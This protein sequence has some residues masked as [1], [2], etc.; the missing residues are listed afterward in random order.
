M[1]AIPLL[2][3]SMPDPEHS[4]VQEKTMTR[5]GLFLGSVAAGEGLPESKKKHLVTNADIEACT[6]LDPL[7]MQRFNEA[8]IAGRKRAWSVL[9]FQE[10]FGRIAE[11]KTMKQAEME[12]RGTYNA[13]LSELINMDSDLHAQYL[14]ALESRSHVVLEPI[15]ETVE[16]RSRDTLEGFKGPIPNMAA[17]SRDKLIAESR[18]RVAAIYNR[19]DYGEQK[20]QTN[21]QVNVD[22]AGTL[23]A[24]QT[25]AKVRG[26]GVTPK[27]LQGAIDAT[28]SE[29]PE[30][31]EDDKPTDTVWREEQ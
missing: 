14:R 3:R 8:C 15:I 29:K 19:K 5:W 20:Q 21:V 16:D 24:A 23:E 28:F 4:P 13:R 26:K 12:V 11:G 30:T 17:V 9:Q 10:F 25:R 31:W 7:E 2:P 1:S 27:Q 6:R 18:F 22:Y